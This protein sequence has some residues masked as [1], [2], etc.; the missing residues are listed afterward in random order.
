MTEPRLRAEV[1][2]PGPRYREQGA[3]SGEEFRD[4]VL[5]PRVREAA[6]RGQALRVELEDTEFGYPCGWLEEVFGGLVRKMP[7]IT[8]AEVTPVSTN[9]PD[10]AAEAIGYMREA[11]L[12]AARSAT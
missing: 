6:A 4:D 9:H 5:I 1:K 2:H 10:A 11:A 7:G 12:H 8:P 3:Y